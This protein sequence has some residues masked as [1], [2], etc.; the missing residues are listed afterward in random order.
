MEVSETVL[1]PL[2]NPPDEAC[3]VIEDVSGTS[4]EAGGPQIQ[5]F[6]SLAAEKM[7]EIDVVVVATPR[8]IRIPAVVGA[9]SGNVVGPAA[10]D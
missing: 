7:E 10:L 6:L 5:I 2:E 8:A 3:H 4:V 1:L 9:L